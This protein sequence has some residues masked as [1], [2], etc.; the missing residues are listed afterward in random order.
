MNDDLY[1]TLVI[2]YIVSSLGLLG[3]MYNCDNIWEKYKPYMCYIPILNTILLL[4][5]LIIISIKAIKA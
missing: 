2:I 1:F 4:K 5:E 3:L